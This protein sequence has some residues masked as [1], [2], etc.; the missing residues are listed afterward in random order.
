MLHIR[1]P[2]TDEFGQ[3]T[4]RLR[5]SP[6]VSAGRTA[7][8]TV[9][10]TA[11]PVDDSLVSVTAWT[12]VGRRSVNASSEAIL[13]YAQ[14][15][16]GLLTPVLNAKVTAFIRPPGNESRSVYVVQLYDRGTG[17]KTK[18]EKKKINV[19][20]LL[21]CPCCLREL[22]NYSVENLHRCNFGFPV[23]RQ[24]RYVHE[25]LHLSPF[26][27]V[28]SA[29]PPLGRR[30]RHPQTPS[31]R[32][33]TCKFSFSYDWLFTVNGIIQLLELRWTSMPS[34]GQ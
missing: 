30:R 23:T 4:Y 16:L 25:L 2:R 26:F 3:W 22:D 15:T 33:L 5:F 21:L 6:P 24:L 28:L 20:L 12:N 31:I 11:Q 27:F 10:V 1:I 9:E 7:R 14:V 18:K 13:I 29:Y 32:F 17:G 8:A 19:F 34:S